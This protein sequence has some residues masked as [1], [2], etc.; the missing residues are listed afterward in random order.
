MK[1]EIG[2]KYEIYR[3]VKATFKGWEQ[4]PRSLE[5][6]NI[7][8]LSS[9]EDD[10]NVVVKD[11]N[12]DFWFIRFTSLK[13]IDN[14]VVEEE[15]PVPAEDPFNWNEYKDIL[16]RNRR[17]V[18]PK[19]MDTN[20]FDNCKNKVD[21]GVH[22]INTDD[23]G[24]ATF[25]FND[26]LQ[27][28]YICYAPA[29]RIKLFNF[30]AAFNRLAK[31]AAIES[32][33]KEFVEWAINESALARY[34]SAKTFEEITTTITPM[35]F[36]D[37]D[38][39]SAIAACCMLRWAYESPNFLKTWKEL[40]DYGV[41]PSIAMFVAVQT[42]N[43]TYTT[44]NGHSAIYCARDVS[45][46]QW[47]MRDLPKFTNSVFEATGNTQA[48]GGDKC[49]IKDGLVKLELMDKDRYGYYR[50]KGEIGFNERV[51]L[52]ELLAK[53]VKEAIGHG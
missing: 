9:I 40:Y 13:N 10:K 17:P 53:S 50:P 48:Y 18:D 36:E 32:G 47:A 8:T 4:L 28:G 2:K 44:G 39:K 3:S 19:G 16:V 7:V 6:G 31:P 33:A 45:L 35:V 46:V 29:M 30:G 22:F 5:V 42:N 26:T 51:K 14:D 24:L 12:D 49:A 27:K 23:H 11:K 41:E 15:V 25:I 20:T 43:G 1:L 52:S 38:H 37:G 34:F 21:E